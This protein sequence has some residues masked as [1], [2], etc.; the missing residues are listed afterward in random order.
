M[1]L[2]ISLGTHIEIF[3]I[4]DETLS[5]ISY[6]HRVKYSFSLFLQNVQKFLPHA[7]DELLY[8]L[9]GLDGKAWW[10][11]SEAKKQIA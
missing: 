4:F 5:F 2:W 11:V 7:S 10:M 3:S 1:D 8:I 6:F 9:K